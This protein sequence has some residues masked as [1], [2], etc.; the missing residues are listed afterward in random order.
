MCRSHILRVKSHCA[1]ENCT[2]RVEITLVRV[3]ITLT[4]VLFVD[5]FVFFA[6]MDRRLHTTH[7]TPIVACFQRV[8]R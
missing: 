1:G 4:R 5:F 3:E 6:P 2:F 8:F 7:R